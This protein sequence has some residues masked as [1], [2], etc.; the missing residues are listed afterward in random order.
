MKNIIYYFTGTGNSLVVARLLA[1]KIN[2]ETEL[3]AITN[4]M[5]QDE[6]VVDAEETVGFVFPIY[7]GDAP[8]PVKAV[9]EKM[10]IL[11]DPYIYA[12]GTCNERGG[13]CMD[14]F[15]G[16]MKRG[17]YKVSYGKK[18]DMP[19]NCMESNAG[20]NAER[21]ELASSRVDV[22]AKNINN[23]FVGSVHEFDSPD[24]TAE[25]TKTVS[26]VC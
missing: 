3:R 17:G 8:W 11:N 9:V 20:E 16:L 12:I 25:A 4:Y 18:I 26:V 13:T 5:D 14:L 7:G 22:F 1:E 23:R 24:N 21:I 6:V 10:K 2:G 15:S 19:G